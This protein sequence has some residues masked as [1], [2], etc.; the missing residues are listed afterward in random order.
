MKILDFSLLHASAAMKEFY[1]QGLL[2]R[3]REYFLNM[4]QIKIC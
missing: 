4:G 2:Q 1:P 3:S